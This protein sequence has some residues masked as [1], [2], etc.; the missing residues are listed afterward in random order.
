MKLRQ[1]QPIGIESVVAGI[2]FYLFREC[3]DQQGIQEQTKERK[4]KIG[5]I[6]W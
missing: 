3:P 6:P 4:K 1:P 5:G 2:S